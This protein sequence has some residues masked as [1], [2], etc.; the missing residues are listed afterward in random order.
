MLLHPFKNFR[1][2]NALKRGQ[3]FNTCGFDGF[4]LSVSSTRHH[5]NLN[6]GG[7]GTTD[8]MKMKMTSENRLGN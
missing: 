1:T 2:H 5:L 8:S 4:D 7:F 3:E 6:S